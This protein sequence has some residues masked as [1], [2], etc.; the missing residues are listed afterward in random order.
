MIGG[1]GYYTTALHPVEY[2]LTVKRGR[3][4]CQS[5]AERQKSSV[6]SF[7]WGFGVRT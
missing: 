4:V 5:M 6:T 1:D 2:V 7:P 3:V